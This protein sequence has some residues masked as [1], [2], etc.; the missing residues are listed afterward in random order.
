M[1][2]TLFFFLKIPEAIQGLL[3]FYINFW[4][5]C[6]VP[7]KY[8]YFHRNPT[9]SID[10]FV[11]LNTKKANNPTKKRA[12]DLKKYF[13]KEAN[14]H[15]KRFSMSLIIREM[16]IKTTMRYHLIPVRMAITNKSTN[17][18]CWWECGERGTLLYVGGNADWCS[19]CG[20]EYGDTSKN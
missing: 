4:N 3:W 15:I 16:Q 14:R 20:K 9:E 10:F 7:V 11:Q 19:H 5:V 6:S 17:N 2:P 18:K 13:S 12:K 1:P 8:W